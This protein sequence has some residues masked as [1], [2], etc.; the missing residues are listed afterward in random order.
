[1]KLDDLKNKNR[2]IEYSRAELEGI[3]EVRTKRS[4]QNINRTMLKDALTMLLTAIVFIAITFGLGLSERYFIAIEIVALSLLLLI[5][6]RVKYALLN[7]INLANE[8]LKVGLIK[9]LNRV[10]AYMTIYKMVIPL[11]TGLIYLRT[12]FILDSVSFPYI[13]ILLP[14]TFTIY[15]LTRHFCD[16][17]YGEDINKLK[18]LLI[19]LESD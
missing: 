5:H 4:I 16:R 10:N 12:I 14:L 18:G 6:Y 8:G 3:F 11:F 13:I 1:M 7:N 15:L 9:L 17:I 19:E 2:P